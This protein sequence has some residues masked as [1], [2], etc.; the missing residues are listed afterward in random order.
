MGIKWVDYTV[1]YGKLGWMNIKG[2]LIYTGS[3]Q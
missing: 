2:N 1:T 3:Q